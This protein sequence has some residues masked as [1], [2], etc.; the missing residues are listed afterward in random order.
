VIGETTRVERWM[1]ALAERAETDAVARR[2]LVALVNGMF[3][4]IAAERRRGGRRLLD[5]A[6]VTS[7][8]WGQWRAH[9]LQ[10]RLKVDVHDMSDMGRVQ[11]W[12]DRAFGVTGHWTERGR[13]RAVKCETACPFAKVASQAPEICTEVVHALEVA[14]FRELHPGYRLLPLERLLSKG[15]SACEFVHVLDDVHGEHP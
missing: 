14:T 15:D 7:V 5:L 2:V 12:E 1:Y 10:E 6:H 8:R 3:R 9:R 11:D 4:A 13:Q